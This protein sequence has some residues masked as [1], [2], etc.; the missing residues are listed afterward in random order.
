LAFKN[1]LKIFYA[2]FENPEAGTMYSS[3]YSAKVSLFWQ[4]NN[5]AKQTNKKVRAN[6]FT[7]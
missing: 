4:Q 7:N 5:K 3:C 1:I 2:Y 6:N